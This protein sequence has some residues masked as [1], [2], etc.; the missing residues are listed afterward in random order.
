MSTSRSIFRPLF[1][2]TCL[3]LTVLGLRNTYADNSEERKLAE[4][5]ACGTAA[6]STNLLSESRNPVA[7]AFAFQILNSKGEATRNPRT[8]QVECKREFVFLGGYSCAA[9]P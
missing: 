4:Q 6:C 3:A 9:K 5:I 2:V 1:T 7:Q 8:V